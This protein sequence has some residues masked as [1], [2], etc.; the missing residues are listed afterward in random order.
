[1]KCNFYCRRRVVVSRF[2]TVKMLLL[3]TGPLEQVSYSAT[4]SCTPVVFDTCHTVVPLVVHVSPITRVGVWSDL[5]TGVRSYTCS[6]FE[7]FHTFPPWHRVHVHTLRDVQIC[8]ETTHPGIIHWFFVSTGA[9]FIRFSLI[10]NVFC[11][12]SWLQ[13]TVRTVYVL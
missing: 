7:M 1:M 3:Y 6:A 11:T 12:C 4:F 8:L 5:C 2:R 9:K 10:S 13:C